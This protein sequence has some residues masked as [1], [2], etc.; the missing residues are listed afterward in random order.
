M[1]KDDIEIIANGRIGIL[2]F[3]PEA[4]GKGI[5]LESPADPFEL[6][7]TEAN[8]FKELAEDKEACAKLVRAIHK[9]FFE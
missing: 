6:I 3:G 9:Y 4:E 2:S 1:E 5:M 8:N 7:E